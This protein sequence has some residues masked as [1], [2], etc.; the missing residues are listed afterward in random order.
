MIWNVERSVSSTL[1][2]LSKIQ[3]SDICALFR[4]I[5]Y[6]ATSKFRNSNF[7]VYNGSRVNVQFVICALY[8]CHAGIPSP[9]K[10]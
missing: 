5:L 10:R 8:H 4:K 7:V 2:K 6:F 1:F 9:E 3:T